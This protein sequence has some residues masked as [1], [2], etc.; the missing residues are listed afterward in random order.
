MRARCGK[1]GKIVRIT[2]VALRLV[3][4]AEMASQCLWQKERVLLGD[5]HASLVKPGHEEGRGVVKG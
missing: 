4:Q 3:W 1:H 2:G 5:W